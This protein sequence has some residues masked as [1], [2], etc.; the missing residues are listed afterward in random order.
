MEIERKFL[1]A[2]AF[3]HLAQRQYR[4]V[5]G[6]LSSVP[7]RTVRIR[8]RDTAGYITVKGASDSRGMS[9]FEWEKEIPLQDA[10]AMLALCEVG[11]IEKVRYE[12]PHDDHIIEVDEFGGKLEGL[13]LAEIEIEREDIPI[14]LPKWIGEEVT[15]DKRYYNSQLVKTEKGV[16]S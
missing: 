16:G 3:K 9:R 2:G 4:I 12:V 5:Q 15:G 11:R 14:S 10:E 13:I 8:I 7:E 1:V 6:Y